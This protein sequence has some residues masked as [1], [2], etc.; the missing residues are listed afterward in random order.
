RVGAGAERRRLGLSGG[1][2]AVRFP[3]PPAT[4]RLG[5]EV[6]SP[7]GSIAS[8]E[9]LELVAS[10]GGPWLYAVVDGSRPAPAGT[11]LEAS[12]L[13]WLE[14]A[15]S[16]S[17]PPGS[18]PPGSSQ[19]AGSG[20]GGSE[21]PSLLR[22]LGPAE[23]LA[24]WQAWLEASPP[25]QIWLSAHLVTLELLAY[26]G[27]QPA[28]ATGR[29]WRRIGGLGFAPSHP[30]FWGHLPTDESLFA[31]RAARLLEL[32]PAAEALHAEAADPRFPFAAPENPGAGQNPGARRLLLP[33]GDAGAGLL[34]PLPE[35]PDPIP[36]H[37]A[38]DPSGSRL[39][40]EGL[41]PLLEDSAGVVRSAGLFVDRDLAG[42]GVGAL[43]GAAEHKL[44]LRSEALDGL[45]ALWSVPEASLV[46]VP[47]AVHPGL[48]TAVAPGQPPL[49]AP[50]LDPAAGPDRFG[51]VVFRWSAVEGAERYLLEVSAEPD[52]ET[53]VDRVYR[54]SAL[55]VPVPSQA[56]LPS[57]DGCPRRVYARVRSERRGERGP[58]SESRDL[59]LPEPAFFPCAY[60]FLGLTEP[61]VIELPGNVERIS[62]PAV[63]GARAYELQTASEPNFVSPRIHRIEAGPEGEAPEE[64]FLDLPSP[65]DTPRYLRVRALGIS[66]GPADAGQDPGDGLGPWSVTRVRPA[67]LRSLPV[68]ASASGEAARTPLLAVQ[69][70]L[71]RFCAARADLV[72]LLSLPRGSDPEE[73]RRH[74]GRLAPSLDDP[75]PTGPAPGVGGGSDSA[76]AGVP[77]L[78]LGEAPILGF[79]AVFHPWLAP[80]A[81]RSGVAEPDDPAA[82]GFGGDTGSGPATLGADPELD[83]GRRMPPD[84]AVAGLCA[85]FARR[86]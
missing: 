67:G 77:P 85:R 78:T 71:L 68:A 10:P 36:T 14:P 9:L 46:A 60:R 31:P 1:A 73:A 51:R 74:L 53:A 83:A 28:T 21:G 13:F 55:S 34:R 72:A 61:S 37:G 81:G 30:R 22:P 49:R 16:G 2:G 35:R 48:S 24:R 62:W 64:P 12:H 42:H 11:F 52:F 29:P 27:E 54:G 33:L 63:P 15:T 32:D 45:H 76:R 3:G 26:P 43:A 5:L 25:D 6:A 57:A 65:V 50:R 41:G 86:Q 56:L 23:G 7:P 44:Y 18:S 39:E 58:F 4:A 82:V 19:S 84:G 47:D 8:G 59:F 66:P 20:A 38:D 70:A 79:G 40:R 75:V 80:A 17:S 69:R